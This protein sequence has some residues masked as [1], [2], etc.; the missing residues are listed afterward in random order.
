MQFHSSNGG[1]IL[2][3]PSSNISRPVLKIQRQNTT[4]F[5]EISF[6]NTET[7]KNITSIPGGGNSSGYYSSSARSSLSPVSSLSFQ[8]QYQ[9]S[10]SDSI[11]LQD[12][13]ALYDTNNTQT[14][15][16]SSK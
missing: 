3:K 10:E 16:H 4:S 12:N 6:I 5:D 1:S 7:N 11:G 15:N 13:S 9:Q 8:F 14:Y 2:N